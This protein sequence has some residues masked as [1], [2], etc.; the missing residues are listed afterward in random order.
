MRCYATATAYLSGCQYAHSRRFWM[1]TT[2]HNVTHAIGSYLENLVRYVVVNVSVSKHIT[3]WIR[4]PCNP[5]LD[6]LYVNT[7][8]DDAFYQSINQNSY[9]LVLL[10]YWCAWNDGLSVF[11][12][13]AIS[14]TEPYLRVKFNSGG[15]TDVQLVIFLSAFCPLSS[16][17][18]FMIQRMWDSCISLNPTS[19]RDEFITI[20]DTYSQQI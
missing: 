2:R 6:H 17:C 13:P 12:W 16:E 20:L 3:E 4:R 19:V 8:R 15:I 14:A 7:L 9:R 1:I 10:I 5:G 18:F 11:V